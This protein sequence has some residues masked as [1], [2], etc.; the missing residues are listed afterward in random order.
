MLRRVRRFYAKRIVNVNINI[1]LAGLLA[2]GPTVLFVYLLRYAGIQQ[3]LTQTDKLIIHAVTLVSDVTFDVLFY[4]VLHWIANHWPRK[5]RRGIWPRCPSCGYDRS[6]MF[7]A[8]ACPACGAEP[9][10]FAGMDDATQEK[11]LHPRRGFL[12]DSTIVQFQ[13][14]LLSPLLYVS[15]F[16]LQNLLMQW[17]V[18]Q[19]IATVVGF[20]LGILM[21]RTLHTMWMLREERNERLSFRRIARRARR[22]S[23]KRA[24]ATSGHEPGNTNGGERVA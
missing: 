19:E 24:G 17:G 20:C 4:Y 13:R 6:G 7:D 1:V 10:E 21:T 2:L 18:E 3:P 12:R 5:F 16:G 22:E 15:W 11:L 14:S 8:E 23:R 9:Y